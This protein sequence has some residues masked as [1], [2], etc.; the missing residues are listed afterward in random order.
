MGGKGSGGHNRKPTAVKKLEGNA[1]HRTLNESEPT[2]APGEPKMPA[3]M[4]TQAQRF[5][6]ELLPVVTGMKVMTPADAVALGQLCM[7][8]DRRMQA[9]E[10]I[11]KHGIL[12]AELGADGKTG[13]VKMNPAVR[14]AS[15]AE[16][17][18]RAYL[19]A[20]G[21]EPSAR[22]KISTPNDPTQDPLDDVF[23]GKDSG[24]IVQ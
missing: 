13:K 16:R 6:G 19:S 23:S 18:V 21:L 4:S 15:D 22:S 9:E 20:F 17:H 7:A 3:G 1:G 24:E 10:A 11:S 14:V 5:W 8:L 2:P 12:I